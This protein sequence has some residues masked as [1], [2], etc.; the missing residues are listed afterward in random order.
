LTGARSNSS[1]RRWPDSGLSLAETTPG[2]HR[3]EE[4]F[5]VLI[6]LVFESE[7]LIRTGDIATVFPS[8]SQ[9]ARG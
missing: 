7:A 1:T 4:I 6:A 8:M 3:H 2:A 9:L 5:R